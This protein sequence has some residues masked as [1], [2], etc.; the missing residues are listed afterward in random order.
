MRRARWSGLALA[1]GGRSGRPTRRPRA[2]PA[3]GGSSSF[4]GWT[5]CFTTT[6]PTPWFELNVPCVASGAMGVRVWQKNNQGSTM[7]LNEIQVFAA[8]EGAS[9]AWLEVDLGA[10]F[11]VG[12]AHIALRAERILPG[13]GR[14]RD[15]HRRRA[16]PTGERV[17]RLPVHGDEPAA[18]AGG[19]A[20][21][22]RRRDARRGVHRRGPVR[23]DLRAGQRASAAPQGGATVRRAR[24]LG[25]V[26]ARAGRARCH[27][28]GGDHVR[29]VD[30]NRRAPRR[31]VHEPQPRHLPDGRRL[32]AH[33]RRR[34]VCAP[35]PGAQPAHDAAERAG[36]HRLEHGADRPRPRRLHG[37]ARVGHAAPPG[38]AQR[39]RADVAQGV[40][41]RDVVAR[42]ARGVRPDDRDRPG[43]RPGRRLLRPRP[44][45]RDDRPDGD[46]RER[47]ERHRRP[48]P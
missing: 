37:G 33:Q 9:V 35:R 17:H 41:R 14:A 36:G 2:C 34:A 1:A 20:R 48:Q 24:R 8:G 16:G 7:N 25:G 3:R 18:G 44:A 5:L 29:R 31:P 15:P 23:V 43:A 26:D 30:G 28:G 12:G 39:G 45:A 38:G 21:F 13:P 47:R 42:Q 46:G 4:D 32:W 11:S 19:R 27:R 22:R 10:R 6:D 40:G